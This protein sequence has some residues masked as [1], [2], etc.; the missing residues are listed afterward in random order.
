MDLGTAAALAAVG[1]MPVANWAVK[2]SDKRLDRLENR[3]G[4]IAAPQAHISA[5]KPNRP[6]PAAPFDGLAAAQPVACHTRTAMPRLAHP[7]P[8]S[9]QTVTGGC[10]NRPHA[11]LKAHTAHGRVASICRT[12]TPARSVHAPAPRSEQPQQLRLSSPRPLCRRVK[13]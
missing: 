1:G 11:P 8:E 10:G 4:R 13:P 7:E 5:A 12:P 9:R 3:F 2:P 6:K